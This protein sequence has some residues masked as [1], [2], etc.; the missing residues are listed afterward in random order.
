VLA[1]L[2]CVDAVSTLRRRDPAEIIRRV[3]PDI[4][5]K[6]PTGRRIRS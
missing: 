6:D 2:T 5:V 1:A 3:Q 4:L